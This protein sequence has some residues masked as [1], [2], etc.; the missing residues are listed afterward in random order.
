MPRIQLSEISKDC[1]SEVCTVGFAMHAAFQANGKLLEGFRLTLRGGYTEVLHSRRRIDS[2][3][4]LSLHTHT[5]T[6]RA[7]F[8]RLDKSESDCQE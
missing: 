2:P 3:S 7:R 5:W 6:L 4:R 1:L 8:V